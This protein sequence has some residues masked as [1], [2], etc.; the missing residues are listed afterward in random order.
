MVSTAIITILSE[1]RGKEISGLPNWMRSGR[2]AGRAP[3][4]SVRTPTARAAVW[5]RADSEGSASAA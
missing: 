3:W 2:S 4:R 5:M 1:T